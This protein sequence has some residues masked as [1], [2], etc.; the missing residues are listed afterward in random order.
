MAGRLKDLGLAAL[1]VLVVSGIVAAWSIS[2]DVNQLKRTHSGEAERIDRQLT[3]QLASLETVLVSL[4]GLYHA[5]DE[6]NLAETTG[7]SQELLRAYPFISRIIHL[8]KITADER[9]EFE[10][11]MLE[12][13][14]IDF[15]VY[16]HPSAADQAFDSSDD[17]ALAVDF[18]EPMGPLSSALLGYDFASHPGTQEVLRRSVVENRIV[19]SPEMK[20]KPSL[21]AAVYVA[22]PIYLGRYPPQTVES[23]SEMLSGLVLLEIVVDEFLGGT[24]LPP[25]FL[26]TLEGQLSPAVVDADDSHEASLVLLAGDD[27]LGAPYLAQSLS[28]A[29]YDQQIT[30]QLSRRIDPDDIDL[31]RLAGSWIGVMT[32]LGLLIASTA[33]RRKAQRW[34]EAANAVAAAEGERFSQ[35]VDNAFDAVITTDRH[36]NIVSWNRMAEYMFGYS[37]HD[38][39]GK[40]LFPL[41]LADE[42]TSALQREL[43]ALVRQRTGIAVS[44]HVTTTGC[45][46]SGETFAMELAVSRTDVQGDPLLSVFARDIR[47]REESERKIRQLAY[48]DALTKLPNRQAFKEQVTRT[49][50]ASRRQGRKSAVLYLDLDGFK[51]IN[52]TLGHDVGDRLL[53]GVAERLKKQLRK[54]D[55]VGR[56]DGVDPPEQQRTIARLGGDEFTVL[57]VDVRDPLSVTVVARRIQEAVARPFNLAGHEVYVT[58]SIGIAMIPDDGSDV[59]VILKNADTAM[60]HAKSIGKNNFQFYAEDMNNRAG[61]RLKLE[62]DLRRA[63]QRRELQLVYQPQVDIAT[64]QIVA[65]EALL[66]WRHPQ[67]GD[68]PPFEF[69]PLAEETG[70]II[71]IGERVLNEACRQNKAWLDEGVPPIKVAV[72]LSPVQFIQRELKA[73]VFHALRVS[74]LP[75]QQ[76]ELEITESILMRNVEETIATLHQI[77]EMGVAL[78]VD[79]FGT[80]YSSLSYLKRFPIDALK[81]DR[82]FVKDIPRDQD[83]MAITAAIIAMG[84]Q[85]NLEIV[86][87]G[88]ESNEQL[89][90]LRQRGCETAQGYLIGKPVAADVLHRQLLGHGTGNTRQRA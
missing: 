39:V 90:F 69:I 5:S 52:D 48:Y 7:F 41:I 21:K 50:S 6:L 16:R 11:T 75:P 25:G 51:R 89:A 36:G 66:R 23:R 32:L 9:Q 30:L 78:S 67:L 13:G 44:R 37:P 88:V 18:M 1:V 64:G 57:L 82:S 19:A 17:Y 73:S 56:P 10:D 45:D 68:I 2:V 53:I 74:G 84:H 71:E 61:N 54:E 31:A 43:L 60:Y 77:R 62:G 63:M 80:G 22:K 34:A 59:D 42:D 49:V 87:E 76:L 81:I 55:Q 29:A 12:Q 70:M 27:N 24:L 15:R 4:S 46:R 72:N 3:Q 14:L 28:L 65:A 38:V 35:V 83:D 40:P 47:E 79:D 26:L 58:P 86:A 33:S 20:L 85:L 8:Q